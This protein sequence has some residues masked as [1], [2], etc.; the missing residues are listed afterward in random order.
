[1]SPLAVLSSLEF[2]ELMVGAPRPVE[3][4][5]HGIR[6]FALDASSRVFTRAGWEEFLTE[7]A[8]KGYRLVQSEWHHARF[9]PA[10]AASPAR[11]SIAVVRRPMVISRRPP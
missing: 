11:S 5:D 4:L 3:E 8:G 2:V 9:F 1:M 6:S 7:L 10:S